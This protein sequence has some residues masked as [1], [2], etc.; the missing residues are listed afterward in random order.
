M[1]KKLIKSEQGSV[2]VFVAIT[3]TVLLGA[4]SLAVDVG[5]LTNERSKLQNAADAAALAGVVEEDASV[6]EQKAKE[7]VLKN[8]TGVEEEDIIV[9][10]PT[11]DTM[12]VTVKKD[13]K[14]FFSQVLTGKTENEVGAKAVAKY[15]GKIQ[16]PG[17]AIWAENEIEMKN[18]AY[19]DGSIH[20]NSNNFD[21]KAQYTVTGQMTYDDQD[22]PYYGYLEEGV[23]PFDLSLATLKNKSITITEST[24]AALDE[25]VIYYISDT[26]QVIIDAPLTINLIT[27]GPIVFNG[28]SASVDAKVLYSKYTSSGQNKPAIE[29]NG[30]GG[31]LNVLVYTPNGGVTW[32][33]N[34]SNLNGA[35]ICQDFIENGSEGMVIYDED[36]VGDFARLVPRLVE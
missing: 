26:R 11:A 15:A 20:S 4:V 27:E 19:V 7:Y 13:C 16:A 33:G 22:M 14:E 30:G 23:I 18:K 24:V 34:G 12:K 32:N 8:T 10:K 28:G 35:I 36:V 31:D 25:N 6:G 5:S 21:F 29:L 3:M 9:T 2:T 1:F 17:Y